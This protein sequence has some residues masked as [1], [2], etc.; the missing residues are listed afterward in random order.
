[1][2]LKAFALLFCGLFFA[3]TAFAQ[4][5]K[6]LVNGD[7]I[8]MVKAGFPD[9]TVIKA[10]EA[11]QTNFDV[12]VP[13]LMELKNAGVS[14]P[15]IDAMLSAEAKKNAPEAAPKPANE[16]PP[17]PNNPTSPH[18]PGIYWLSK[19]GAGNR[20]LRLEASAYSQTKTGGLFASGMTMGIHKG[21]MKAVLS[22]EHAALRITEPNP[23]FYFYFNEKPQGFGQSS[24]GSVQAS[25]PEEFALA[26]MERHGKER[27]LNVGEIGIGTFGGASSGLSSKDTV[28]MEVQNVAPGIYEVTPSKPL[29]PGEYCF[30]PPSG[31]AGFGMAGGAVF[32]FGVDK[33]Q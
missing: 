20:M 7:V 4:A 14:Q 2:K 31:A 21:K 27:T 24:P 3:T 33:G 18:N 22:G 12:S 19:S 10:I 23:K 16:P 1:M 26:E 30:V 32:D 8:Q 15:L 25:K 6:P 17:D 13:A 28:P 29:A 9:A 11:N 5:N